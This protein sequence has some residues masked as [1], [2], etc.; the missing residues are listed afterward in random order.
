MQLAAVLF[1][2]AA[3]GGLLM[4][5]IRLSGTPRPPIWL[6]LGHGVI[7]AGGLG[8]LGYAAATQSLPTVGL[9]A[10]GGFILAALGGATLLIAF[11]L[12]GKP[13]PIPLVIGHGL[14]AIA[15]FVLLLVGIFQ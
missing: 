1:A 9:L 3:L 5:G 4:A 2:L 12:Q 14:L 15:S 7:A 8:T 11:H 10:L 6:A 13:L